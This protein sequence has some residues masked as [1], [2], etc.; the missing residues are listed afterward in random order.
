MEGYRRRKSIFSKEFLL[1]NIIYV[2]VILFIIV[3]AL[4]SDR[5]LTG[6]NMIN[7]LTQSTVLMALCI[8]MALTMI[9]QGIDMS[10]GSLLFLSAAVMQFCGKKLGW[11]APAMCAAGLV[12]GT[13]V[14]TLNGVIAAKLHVYPLLTTL[15][16]MY[17]C[18]GL[19]LCITGGGTGLMPMS[20]GN[21]TSHKLLG[22][23]A[24]VYI[25]ILIAILF[26]IF[27]TCTGFGRHI[28][29][30]GDSEKT[31][32]EKGINITAVKIF[33]YAASGFMAAVAGI[34]SSSQVVSVPANLGNNQETMAI[35]AAVLGGTSLFGGKGSTFP[36]AL[37]GALIM[38]CIS[39]S[40]VLLGAPPNAYNV[41]YACVIFFVV[42]IDT[43]KS[44][45]LKVR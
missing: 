45:I 43:I 38:S 32:R 25:V 21:L 42:F 35:I 31:A 14:G 29:A 23:P 37:I 2:I 12:V 26:Q 30:V 24:Q 44:K 5:F 10:M 33:V 4:V 22:I 40:L 1:S 6:K 8:G 39:N 15:A 7:I 20:W 19:G 27:L 3:M 16:T 28:F 41:V 18:R 36:C 17:A 11:S 9:T 13:A 34:I